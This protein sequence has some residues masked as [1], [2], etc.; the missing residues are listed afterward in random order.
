MSV[1]GVAPNVASKEAGNVQD[2]PPHR[3][4][5]RLLLLLMQ[6]SVRRHSQTYVI[7]ECTS[8]LH[9]EKKNQYYEIWTQDSL[10][11]WLVIVVPQSLSS[12]L[13]GAMIDR[14]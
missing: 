10:C 2:I 1:S 9:G 7:L 12:E 8:F 4:D 6:D 3:A 13:C 14:Q 5:V 11:L